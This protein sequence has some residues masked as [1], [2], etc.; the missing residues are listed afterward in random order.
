MGEEMGMSNEF[1]LDRFACKEWIDANR[2]TVERLSQF[3][4]VFSN[5]TRLRIMLLLMKKEMCVGRI[6]KVLD[7]DPSAISAQLRI[8]RHLNLV[9]TRRHGKYI[10]YTLNDKH[11]R[12]VLKEGFKHVI[13]DTDSKGR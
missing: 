3:F 13:K 12:N 7:M 4:S 1:S 9:K 10:R 8:L 5:P 2:E 11:V 6:A